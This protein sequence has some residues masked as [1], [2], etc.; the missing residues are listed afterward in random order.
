MNENIHGDPKL[1]IPPPVPMS[2]C[3][4]Y[5]MQ[6]S[7]KPN[8]FLFSFERF[9]FSKPHDGIDT[10]RGIEELSSHP[11]FVINQLCILVHH[12]MSLRLTFQMKYVDYICG[13]PTFQTANHHHT[14]KCKQ[15]FYKII[16]RLITCNALAYFTLF[17]G[18]ASCLKL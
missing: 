14:L 18:L 11:S 7:T 13:F 12:L 1:P 6:A 15:K 4:F 2:N 16:L 17:S 5:S 10:G 8:C 3:S 9:A